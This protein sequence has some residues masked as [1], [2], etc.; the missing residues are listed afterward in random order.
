MRISENN[1]QGNYYSRSLLG[2][3]SAV[4]FYLIRREPLVSSIERIIGCNIRPVVK[5]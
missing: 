3:Q 1:K 2:N 4:G 5:P